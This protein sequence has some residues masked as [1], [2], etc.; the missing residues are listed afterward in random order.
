MELNSEWIALCLSRSTSKGSVS[1][2]HGNYESLAIIKGNEMAHLLCSDLGLTISLEII[3]KDVDVLYSSK[4]KL[5]ARLA[6][7]CIDVW[8]SQRLR[9]NYDATTIEVTLS[10]QVFGTTDDRL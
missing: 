6:L 4:S 7:S 5:A 3:F 2:T 10:S 8:L 1:T 9:L